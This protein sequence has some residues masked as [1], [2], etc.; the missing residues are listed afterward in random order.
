MPLL[1]DALG[2][3]TRMAA[4]APIDPPAAVAAAIAGDDPVL[5]DDPRG[6]VLALGEEM[7]ELHDRLGGFRDQRLAL[8]RVGD[9]DG[10]VVIDSEI[11][12]VERSLESAQ[13]R[14]DAACAAQAAFER[15]RRLY[16]WLQLEPRLAAAHAAR[17]HAAHLLL[18]AVNKCVGLEEEAARLSIELG[19]SRTPATG[20]Y[21]DYL[22]RR[23]IDAH[24]RRQ[25]QQ[26]A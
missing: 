21:T 5:P 24:L 22:L 20:P 6:L 13:V 17:D 11:V 12:M 16:A 4:E 9:L 8:L 3:F 26:A 25:P 1:K 15:D 2:R 23:W 10:V 7:A 19:D 18:T 14:R